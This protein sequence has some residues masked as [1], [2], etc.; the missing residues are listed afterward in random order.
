MNNPPSSLSPLAVWTLLVMATGLTF[1]A[2]E[3]GAPGRLLILG[4]LALALF[5]GSLVILDFMELRHAPALWRRGV[6]GWLLFVV[7]G[8]VFAY[9]KGTP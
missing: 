8:I 5:K 6:L 4:V 9:L 2:G 7:A 3:F 1:A